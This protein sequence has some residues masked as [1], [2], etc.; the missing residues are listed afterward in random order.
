M[1]IFLAGGSGVIGWLLVPALVT[2]GHEVT[3]ISRRKDQAHELAA[4]G[5]EPVIGDVL[6]ADR[7]TDLVVA[8]RPEAVIQHLTSLPQELSPKKIKAAFER[9]DR[10]RGQGGANLL[11]AAKAAG[12]RRYVAQNV[13]FMY[14]PAGPSVVAEDAPLAVDAPEPYGRSIR[15]HAAMERGVVDSAE[16]EGL[17]LRF[18]FW[19]GP[20]T[21]FASGGYTARQVLRRRYPVVGDGSGMFSFVHV[22]DVVAATIAALGH[23]A[24]GVYNVC[25]DDPAPV[26]E[27]LPAYAR[28]VG[29]PAPRHL[30][31]WLARLLA[32][33]YVV[34]QATQMRGAS[35]HKAKEQLGWTPKYPSWR[36]GFV[37]ALG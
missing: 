26:R 35:N 30:S 20:G 29:A 4:Q 13:C 11:A 7:L 14:A 5:A 8:A 37:E 32:G 19:Y 21:T 2:A 16:L 31:A 18:G 15:T 28:A 17:V 25:D 9:N 22:H 6:D 23:G 3:A 33:P 34:Y 36:D 1:K 24:P 27:W 10:V 12:A